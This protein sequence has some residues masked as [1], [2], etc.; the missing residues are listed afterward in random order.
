[1]R[2][3]RRGAGIWPWR[4]GAPGPVTGSALLRHPALR[5]AAWLYPAVTVADVLAT[6]NHYLLDVVTAP[7]VL[8]LAYAIAAS[9]ALARRLGLLPVRHRPRGPGPASRASAP[10]RLGGLHTPREAPEAGA[11]ARPASQRTA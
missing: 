11:A 2:P 5:A 8:L 3:G 1:M 4:C 6:A 7:A 10:V 9:P